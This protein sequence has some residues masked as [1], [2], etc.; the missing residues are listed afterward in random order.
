M[1]K[2]S[3]PAI[4]AVCLFSNEVVFAQWVTF[5]NQTATRLS[6]IP[7]VGSA[8]TDEKDFA[9]GDFDKDGDLDLISVNKLIGTNGGMRRG[10][11]F[12]N[13]NGVMTDRTNEFASDA[14][15]T[16]QG[17]GASQGLLDTCAN[18][19]LVIV[20][21]NGDTWLDFV[22]SPTL[23][24]AQGKAKSHPR[25]YINQ[26]DSPLGSGNWQGFIFDDV[27]R[28]PTM[29]AEP[30]FCAVSAGDIDQDGDQ[31]L[32]F[33]DYEQGGAR[34]VDVN[35]RLLINDGTG[36][37]TDQSSL[38]MTVEMLESSFGM[39]TAIVDMNG[40]GR[41]DILKDDA[42]NAPQA[43]SVSYNNLNGT[44]TTG[45]FNAYQLAYDNLAPYH[46]AVGDLNKDNRPDLVVTDDNQ[47]RYRLNLGNSANGQ[48]NW[49]ST[50]ILQGSLNGTFGGDNLIA[51]LN[52]DTFPDVMVTSVDVDLTNCTDAGKLFRNLGNLPNVTLT[53]QGTGGISAAHLSGSH[54]AVAFDINQDGWLDIFLGDCEGNYVY[55][56]QPPVGLTFG[57]PSGLPT[58]VDPGA[59]QSVQVQINALGGSVIA[60]TEELHYSVDGGAFL[61]TVMTSLGSGLYE[62][63]LPILSCAQTLS[64]YFTADATGNI[65]FKDPPNAPTTTFNAMSAFDTDLVLFDNFETSGGAGWNVVNSATGG[66]WEL[67]TPI[68]TLTGGGQQAAPNQDAEASAQSVKCFTTANGTQGGAVGDADVDGGPTD[69]LSPVIDLDGTDANISYSRWFFCDDFPATPAQADTLVVSISNTGG[70]PWVTVETV[71]TTNGAWLS[72][73]FLV[74]D[75]VTPTSTVRVRFRTSDSPSNSI[76]E[77]GVDIFRVE[78]LVCSNVNCACASDVNN[79]T[80]R[81]AGDIQGFIDCFMGSGANCGC[82]DMNG[83]TQ[84]NSTDVDAFVGSM[85]ATLPCN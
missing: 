32:Y 64:F 6:A 25:V 22:T 39:S 84:L 10:A 7:S 71:S 27:N 45:F 55:M 63:D 14:T 24:G 17:G 5:N 29:P 47:D 52:N 33:G 57:Y 13:E 85:L 53:E 8:N 65:E 34:P 21:V 80:F 75:F 58:L 60:G 54:D 30:R 9:V 35:D 48:V 74:S 62:V 78:A 42:L 26:K 67:V 16:L 83:D 43:V 12:M 66:K 76:T 11:L 68:G 49:S 72:H 40:D 4:L 37:F 28:I 31:D 19:D 73:T 46:I 2:V 44:G 77:A 70:D 23:T 36:F 59:T 41:L 1:R 15:V 18:R 61:T 82:A 81:D 51:D 69:L 79:D 56:N 3:L 38:R 20:D 50:F